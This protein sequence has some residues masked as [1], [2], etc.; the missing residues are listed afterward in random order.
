MA[1]HT[2][3]M[4][5]GLFELGHVVHVIAHGRRPQTA[6]TDGAFVHRVP[7]AAHRYEGLRGTPTLHPWLCHSHAAH[8]RVRELQRSDGIQLLDSPLW[9]L[10]GLVASTARSLPLVVRIQ[11]AYTQ[12]TAIQK[13]RDPD[14]TAVGQLERE[15]LMRADHLVA[16]TRATLDGA[17]SLYRL[18]ADAPPASVIAHG[19]EP[20]DDGLTRPFDP[21]A[22]RAE[23]TV[24]YV[25]RLERRKGILELFDAIPEVLRRAPGTRFVLAGADNS[26]NDGFA[27][28]TGRRYDEFFEE[29]HP[30]AA[31]AVERP[32]IH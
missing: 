15:L 14:R 25:G 9:H 22:H 23:R 10:D 6:F 5:R 24:L 16:N 1:R 26:E 28:R 29:R 21:D 3:L 11:T 30:E 20:V 27:R 12:I 17:R 18:G 32:R 13:G 4:A 8:E 2:H 19:I 7:P 31:R